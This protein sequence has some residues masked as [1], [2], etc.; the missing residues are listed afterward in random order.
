MFRVRVHQAKHGYFA[1]V[2]EGHPPTRRL[3]RSWGQRPALATGER[4]G[5]RT[6]AGSP[7]KLL[8]RSHGRPEA[9]QPGHPASSWG[10]TCLLC[11]E[12]TN[13]AGGGAQGGAEAA[14]GAWDRAAHGVTSPHGTVGTSGA[15]RE[16]AA[17]K[18]QLP[19][20]WLRPA[21]TRNGPVTVDRALR[22]AARCSGRVPNSWPWSRFYE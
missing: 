15:G 22:D 3:G 2:P 19:E 21:G 10:P 12:E 16:V 11:G 9:S 7:G 8:T 18:A 6:A 4:H 14:L 13:S 1:H 5:H 17:L 20:A